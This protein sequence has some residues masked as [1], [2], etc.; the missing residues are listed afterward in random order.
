MKQKQKQQQ[1]EQEKRESVEY[2]HQNPDCME[3]EIVFLCKR[4][5][6]REIDRF[7]QLSQKA[8]LEGPESVARPKSY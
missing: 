3:F 4:K 7:R 2:S 8:F 1:N 5:E 6:R